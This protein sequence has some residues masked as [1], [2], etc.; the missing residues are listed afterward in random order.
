MAAGRLR[1]RETYLDIDKILAL[2]KRSGADA[3]HP[4]YGYMAENAL[5]AQPSSTP[6]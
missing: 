5:F 4:G 6:D 1:S 2:A 3:I